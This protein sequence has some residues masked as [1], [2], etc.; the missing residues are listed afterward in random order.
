MIEGSGRYVGVAHEGVV[1]GEPTVLDRILQVA[2]T[3][4]PGVLLCGLVIPAPERGVSVL[5]S[6]HATYP[7]FADY[8]PCE[9]CA[10]ID[11]E[12]GNPAP[13]AE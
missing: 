1:G 7:V 2:S 12:S 6:P 4:R 10:E 11:A 13:A 8:E 9:R 3:N 5:A